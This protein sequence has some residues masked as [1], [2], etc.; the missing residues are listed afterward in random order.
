MAPPPRV[1]HALADFLR[2]V[3]LTP[4]TIE[5]VLDLAGLI[6]ARPMREEI[7]ANVACT[8]ALSGDAARA[9]RLLASMI[10]ET[11]RR[12]VLTLLGDAAD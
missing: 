9:R 2:L 10:N 5:R 12:R 1:D 8:L 6:I 3:P 7:A 11:Q 4:A